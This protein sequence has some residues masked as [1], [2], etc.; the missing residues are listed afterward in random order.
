MGLQTRLNA[1]SLPVPE[2]N[3]AFTV[4]TADPLSIGGKSNLTC[5]TSDG[6]SSESLFAILPEVIRAVNQDLIVK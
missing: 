4:S 2:N 6:V 5:I 1:T 3:V